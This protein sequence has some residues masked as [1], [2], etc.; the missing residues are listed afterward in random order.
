MPIASPCDHRAPSVDILIP[1]IETKDNP[2]NFLKSLIV[3]THRILKIDLLAFF[4]EADLQL[5]QLRPFLLNIL[6]QDIPLLALPDMLLDIP[7]QHL[8]KTNPAYFSRLAHLPL[9][10][11]AS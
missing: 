8:V 10:V 2:G 7:Q 4:L 6:P 11:P 3:L 9:V 1:L 5:H